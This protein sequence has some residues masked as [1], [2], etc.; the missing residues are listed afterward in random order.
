MPKS[1]KILS[2]I[3]MN[4]PFEKI[5]EKIKKF[6]DY[7]DWKQFHNPK[8]MAEA[9]VIEAAELLEL[10]LWKSKKESEEFMK[11]KKNREEFADELADI[12]WFVLELAD[13]YGID[14]EKAIEKKLA[15]NAKKY[16]VE[17]S[18]G[19]AIKYTKL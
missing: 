6:R 3:F 11:N 5:I 10:F 19:K 8:D 9:I 13:T 1:A 4:K 12:A 18:K 15:K 17:K 14:I 2:A 7:R 16:P